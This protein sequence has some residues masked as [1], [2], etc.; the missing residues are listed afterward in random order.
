MQLPVFIPAISPRTIKAKDSLLHPTFQPGPYDVI[1]QRGQTPYKHIGNR[2]FRIMIE[3]HVAGYANAPT[4]GDKSLLVISIVDTIRQLSPNGGFVKFCK[5]QNRYVEI[6][7]NL[8]R[9]KVGHALREIMNGK[10]KAAIGKEM[11]DAKNKQ[12]ALEAIKSTSANSK[13]AGLLFPIDVTSSSAAEQQTNS[14]IWCQH[15]EPLPISAMAAYAIDTHKQ[16]QQQLE[17]REPDTLEQ[18]Q[19]SSLAASLSNLR[20]T[21]SIADVFRSIDVSAFEND[22][23]H[24]HFERKRH[25]DLFQF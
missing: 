8:A 13:T 11:G 1:C 23:E 10:K 7:D 20:N 24:E 21:Q 14:S 12:K 15:A 17:L 3:N 25:F 9:E 4:K 5:K 18:M 22:D 19:L 16:Q 6:G 2:R